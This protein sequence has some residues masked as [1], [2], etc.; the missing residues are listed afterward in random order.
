MLCTHVLSITRHSPLVIKLIFNAKDCLDMIA[1]KVDQ[2]FYHFLFTIVLKYGMTL[3][4]KCNFNIY[5]F[6]LLL[7]QCNMLNTENWCP[8]NLN[9]ITYSRNGFLSQRTLHRTL[10][11]Q[12]GL[13]RHNESQYQKLSLSNSVFVLSK[14]RKSIEKVQNSALSNGLIVIGYFITL[15][16]EMLN[17]KEK[18]QWGKYIF[19][20]HPCHS[21][22]LLWPASQIIATVIL[23]YWGAASLW[24]GFS[25]WIVPFGFFYCHCHRFKEL[26][27]CW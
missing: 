5:S 3:L 22:A 12:K 17:Y 7:Y 2:L 16:R 11:D 18:L 24:I 19:Q 26:Q 10:R 4:I 8:Y 25:I 6:A 13:N 15:I 27:Q 9:C 23:E 1:P 20:N 21:M 14:Y